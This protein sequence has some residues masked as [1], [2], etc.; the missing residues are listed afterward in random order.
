MSGK[1]NLVET[2]LDDPKFS[3]FFKALTNADLSD[4]LKNSGPFTI[5]A[6]SNLAFTKLPETKLIELMMPFNKKNLAE[7]IKFHIIAGKIT[8][9]DLVKETGFIT[10]QGQKINI[11]PTDF[12]FEVNGAKLQSRD[13][14]ADNGVIH[15]IN[16]VLFPA[17]ATIVN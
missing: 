7:L 3:I 2:I 11:K 14:E 17:I 6:P 12:G 8:S 5:L 4:T 15:S 16:A 10:L 9:E 1:L 13:I